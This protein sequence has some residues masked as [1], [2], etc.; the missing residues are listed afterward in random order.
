M[1]DLYPQFSLAWSL[2]Q[3]RLRTAEPSPPWATATKAQQIVE[4]SGHTG[5]YAC[6]SSS[7]APLLFTGGLRK[8]ETTDCKGIKILL[9]VC[10]SS[11][12]G[13][14]LL[15]YAEFLFC[16][17]GFQHAGLLVTS[18]ALGFLCL[19][20][21]PHELSPSWA[22]AVL[23]LRLAGEFRLFQPGYIQGPAPDMS[24]KCVISSVPSC[25]SK[26]LKWQTSITARLQLSFIRKN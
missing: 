5:K 25:H 22:S 23:G 9:A 17:P 1:P 19:Q 18:T 8:Q 21:P 12:R 13:E 3:R 10:P 2:A 6:Q 7:V 24:R 20:C 4:P 14:D 26:D 11:H 15:P 16:C